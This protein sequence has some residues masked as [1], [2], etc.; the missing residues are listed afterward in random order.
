MERI[1]EDRVL[2]GFSN[3]VIANPDGTINL[4]GPRTG[5]FILRPG[6]TKNLRTPTMDMG[7]SVTVTL[8]EIR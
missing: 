6:E 3:V 4:S 7:I 2:F 1:V 8:D 5:K